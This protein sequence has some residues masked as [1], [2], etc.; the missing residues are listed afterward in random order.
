MILRPIIFAVRCKYGFKISGLLIL[1]TIIFLQSLFF[2][3]PRVIH[4]DTMLYIQGGFGDFEIKT[5][6]A[7][8]QS[9]SKNSRRHFGLGMDLEK[10]GYPLRVSFKW[11][12]F[13]TGEETEKWTVG[14]I[15]ENRLEINGGT[16]DVQAFVTPYTYSS[17]KERIRVKPFF[18]G[19][20]GYKRFKFERK[21]LNENIVTDPNIIQYISG[22]QA[23]TTIGITPH[24]GFFIELPKLETECSLVVG[25][26]FLAVKANADYHDFSGGGDEIYPVNGHTSGSAIVTGIQIVKNWDSFSVAL[27]YIWEKTR[28]ADKPFL[29]DPDKDGKAEK[30][31]PFHE[32]EIVETFGQLSLS[33][34]F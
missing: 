13:E 11:G 2:L 15:H 34:L 12:F 4:A 5:K 28:I 30:D 25:W 1:L 17:G 18:G 27:G 8:V 31:F 7:L 21:G 9:D 19:G 33:Y 29:Y 32:L 10:E 23:V 3:S 6:D 20:L 24:M 14:P 16:F 22:N 26:S